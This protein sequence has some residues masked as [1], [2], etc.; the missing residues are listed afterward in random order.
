MGFIK[1]VLLDEKFVIDHLK[2]MND[3]N[4]GSWKAR[5]HLKAARRIYNAYHEH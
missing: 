5:E 3:A 1:M 4:Y 2:L